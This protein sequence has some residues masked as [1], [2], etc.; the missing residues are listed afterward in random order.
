[1]AKVQIPENYYVE[2]VEFTT[3][4]VVKRFG[5]FSETKA[6][7]L[8]DGININLDAEEFFTRVVHVKRKKKNREG[9]NS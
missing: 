4:K 9:H 5:P 7:K 2:V 1:M 3:K 8:D 6:N